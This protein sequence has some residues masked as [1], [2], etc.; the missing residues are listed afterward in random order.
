MVPSTTTGDT[1]KDFKISEAVLAK[2]KLE[3]RVHT[4]ISAFELKYG[5]E[6]EDIDISKEY[7][8]RVMV[9]L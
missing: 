7:K 2:K 5:L 1:M 6:V 4:L 9:S 8:S 3:V